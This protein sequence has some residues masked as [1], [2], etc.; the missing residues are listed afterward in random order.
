MR[1]KGSTASKKRLSGRSGP[2]RD[3]K[4]QFTAWLFL[5]PNLA[6]FGVLVIVPIAIGLVLSFF[7]WNLLSAPT[8]LGLDNFVELATD[9]TAVVALRSTMIVVLGAVVPTVF[10]SFLLAN[11]LNGTLPA[12]RVFRIA[13]FS[14]IFIS[15][16]ASA[17]LWRYLF[18][19]RGGI[20]YIMSVLGLPDPDWLGSPT[21]AVVAVIIVLIWKNLPI[22]ILFYLAALQGVPRHLYE[23]ADI[24]GA[25]AWQ[26]M[27]S[28]TWPS[29]A[30][31]TVL[32]TVVTLLGVAFGAFDV[33]VILT[34]GGPLGATN[35][36]PYY[37]YTTAFGDLRFGYAS[38]I[39]SLLFLIVLAITIALVIRQH[40]GGDS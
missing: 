35:V 38:A 34:Q 10:L 5:A 7:A 33:V 37:A 29:V 9:A 3:Y 20:D 26:K 22:A 23:A 19:P 18:A 8:F 32:V 6:L 28:V 1:S 2:H 11:V 4:T 24:D 25:N 17:V 39:S 36:L 40:R 16:V 14:P 12:R 21:W 13:Y 30:S 27:R 15:A 31:V